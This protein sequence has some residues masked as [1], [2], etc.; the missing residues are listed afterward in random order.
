VVKALHDKHG[1]RTT[2]QNLEACR[3]ASVVLVCVKPHEVATA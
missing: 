1:I 3:A 2:S